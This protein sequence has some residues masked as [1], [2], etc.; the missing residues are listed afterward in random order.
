LGSFFEFIDAVAKT[1]IGVSRKDNQDAFGVVK[2]ETLHA[3][4]IA[5]GM[6]GAQGGA[7]AA[8]I[9]IKSVS[10][11]LKQLKELDVESIKE[12][13]RIA[14]KKVYLESCSNVKL[15]GMGTTVVGI[16]VSKQGCY[17]FSVGD[18]RAYRVRDRILYQLTYDHTVLN[19]LIRSG[20]LSEEEAQASDFAHMLTRSV[21]PS[22]EVEVDCRKIS[23]EDGDFYLL[24]SDGLYNL[25]PD[26]KLIEVMRTVHLSKTVD[27]LID[28]AN[29][30][31]GND[32]ITAMVVKVHPGCNTL[33]PLFEENDTLSLP[34]AGDI[35][36]I[37]LEEKTENLEDYSESTTTEISNKPS[38]MFKFLFIISCVV[39]MT[40]LIGISFFLS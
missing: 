29:K 40:A 14:N 1:D 37:S 25:V 26:E 18:S 30:N 2:N 20:T 32:N 4:F 33:V 28:L 10:E 31:G 24:C 12:V 38:K 3:F 15:K 5:D 39:V 11:E 23:I 16:V 21:G 19:D 13:V 36:S 8:K 27:H 34:C 35:N 9:T 17:L 7:L 22:A 6:G